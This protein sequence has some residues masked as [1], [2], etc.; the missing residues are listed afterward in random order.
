MLLMTPGPTPVPEF[1]RLAMA[2]E[3]LHHR[4]PEFE[5]I[6]GRA[7]DA[8]K[9]F[10]KT[11]EILFLAA[12]GSGAME[13]C[14]LNFCG[15]R[16][17]TINAGKFGERFTKIAKTYGKNPVE[18]K[19]P[20]HTPASV[21]DVADALRAN[22]D[23]DALFIQ[24]C[25]SA[26]GLRHPVE[27]I[28]SAA[29]AVRPDIFVVAD[30]ITAVG[31]E[32]I[33]VQNIDALITGSQKAFMLPPGLAMMGLSARAVA[34]LEKTGGAGFYF[35]LMTEL[36]NQRK[37]TT[38]WTAATTLIQGLDAMLAHIESIGEE[39][40]YADTR[41][42][43][44]AGLEALRALKV[45]IYPQ[46]PALSMLSVYHPKAAQLRKWMKKE[47]NVNAAGGQ[48]DLKD[49]LMRIN[50]MGLVSAH[51]IAW[52]INAFEIAMEKLGDRKYDGTG[53][54]VFTQSYYKETK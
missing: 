51:E 18:L 46:T 29:R 24:V 42:R 39:A 20:W 4:T 13:A 26:G 53:M 10:M 31:V 1:I 45:D 50:N 27:A 35:N 47:A 38:A 44:S 12:T 22:P 43:H 34:H 5:A 14:M 16:A 37:N 9:R 25:E 49:T 2:G 11:E 30:G 8:L 48:D 3:T 15:T 7:R 54:R 23:V 52:S 36:K 41:R 33:N 32:P 17:L 28:A 21:E 40:F 19:Y 6:F